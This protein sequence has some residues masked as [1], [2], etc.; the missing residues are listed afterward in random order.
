MFL[1]G[2]NIDTAFMAASGFSLQNGFTS[3]TYSECELKKEVLK[4]ASNIIMLMDSSK[5]GKSLPYTFGTLDDIDILISDGK[6]PDEILE[7]AKQSGTEV[8]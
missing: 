2:V 7:A 3:G 1:S 4:S 8:I 6:L 5:I